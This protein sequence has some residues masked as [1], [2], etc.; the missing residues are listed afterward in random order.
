MITE[1][2]TIPEPLQELRR[3]WEIHQA[4]NISAA[5]S[6]YRKVLQDNPNLATGWNYLG[7]ACFNQNRLNEAV[8]AYQKAIHIKPDYVGAYNNLGNALSRMQKMSEAL[9]CFDHALTL[10]PNHDLALKNKGAALFWNGRIEEA[11]ICYERL[12][13]IDP[14]KPEINTHLGVIYL[15]LGQ[16][17]KGWKHYAWRLKMKNV[18]LREFSQPCWDGSSLSGKTILIVSEQGMGDT[19]QFIRYASV[20]KKRYEC[21]VIFSCQSFLHELLKTCPGID[22]LIDINDTQKKVDVVCPILSIPGMLNDTY[23]TFPKIIPYLS[24]NRQWYDIWKNKLRAYGGYKIGIIWQGNPQFEADFYRSFKLSDLEPFCRL[25]GIHLVSLQKGF[26]VD[27][28]YT[29]GARLPL[30]HLGDEVDKTTGAF[31]E[32]AAILKNLDL[33]I[34]PDTAIAHLAGAL[35]VPTWI[36]LAYIPDWRWF[37]N[38]DDSCFYPSVRLFRQT[39]PGDWT[40][41]FNRMAETLIHEV[42]YVTPRHYSQYRVAEC[43]ANCL[44]QTKHGLMLYPRIDPTIGRSLH[45][46]GEYCEPSSELF[47]QLIQSGHVVI[48]ACAN[49]GAHTLVLSKLVG[50]LGCVHAFEWK[51]LYFQTLCAN[52]GLNSRTNVLCRSEIIGDQNGPIN[53]KIQQEGNQTQTDITKKLNMITIDSLELTAC[54]FLKIDMDGLEFHALKGAVT[55][56]HNHH[57]FVYVRSY[58]PDKSQAVIDYLFSLDYVLYWHCSPLYNEK[59]Y[60]QYHDNVFN[61]LACLNIVGHHSSTNISVSGLEPIQ[62]NG[63]SQ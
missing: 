13:Q 46:Y 30:I 56:I 37:L 45:H 22:E 44:T 16:F 21:Y 36:A 57:P 7:I 35:G 33:V 61:N 31:V 2:P 63:N 17:D 43:G 6:I 18:M 49:I 47:H 27:Q 53:L 20:L 14:N 55:T 15:L 8:T 34:A 1:E 11:L 32:T 59:N 60:F 52:L 10:K 41:V 62:K 40:S 3:G 24:V 9:A 38:R 54:H 19:I 25:H 51:D 4:G 39:S 12:L 48:E 23:E 26:G 28:L 42:P 50:S 58:S 5:E 29:F